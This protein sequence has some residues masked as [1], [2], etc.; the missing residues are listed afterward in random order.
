MSQEI[1]KVKDL[2]VNFYLEDRVIP[3]VDGVSFSLSKGET[4]GYSRRNQD[5]ARASQSFPL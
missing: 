5:V 2:G 4:L 3:A 1:L